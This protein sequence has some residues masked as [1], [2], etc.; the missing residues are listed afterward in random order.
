MLLSNKI[1]RSLKARRG[2]IERYKEW[3]ESSRIKTRPLVWIHAASVGE[4]LHAFPLIQQFRQNYPDVQIAFT[5]YSPSAEKFAASVGADFHAYLPFDTKKNA[6]SILDALRPDIIVFSKL[7]V[8]PRLAKEAH[9]RDVKLALTSATLNPKSLRGTT[10]GKMLLGGTYKLLDVVCAIDEEDANRLTKLGVG[11]KSVHVTGDLRY[12]QVWGKVQNSPSSELVQKLRSDRPTLVAGSTWPVDEKPLLGAWIKLRQQIPNA[13]LILAPHEVNV[14]HI[15][16]LHLW[17]RKNQLISANLREGH[18]PSADVILVDSY[19]VL[20]D[21]YALANV[22]YVGGGFHGAG[23][24]SVVEP[25]AFGIPVLFGPRYTASRD[26]VMLL[27][28]GGGIVCKDEKELLF[29]LSNLFTNLQSLE[30]TGKAAKEL[31]L[32][33][34]GAAGKTFSLVRELLPGIQVAGFAVSHWNG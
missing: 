31:F 17:A 18:A 7:D 1:V 16:S 15:H 25:M 29:V 34:L 8:W 24:H 26:A 5:H 3:G 9:K 22:A 28:S 27:E 20:A 33:E 13:R 2:L 12:D 14:S 6:R 11:K 30:K 23:L 10:L 19:G 4:G 32:R 21:L